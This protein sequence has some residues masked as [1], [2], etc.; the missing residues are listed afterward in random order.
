MQGPDAG[1]TRPHFHG[2]VGFA[3]LTRREQVS[4]LEAFNRMAVAMQVQ[5]KAAPEALHDLGRSFLQRRVI[6]LPC[7]GGTRIAI[8][9]FRHIPVGVQFDPGQEVDDHP[10]ASCGALLDIIGQEPRPLL[11]ARISDRNASGA[12]TVGQAVRGQVSAVGCGEDKREI[13]A[14][15]FDEGLC[16]NAQ[17]YAREQERKQQCAHG[18]TRNRAR[19]TRCRVPARRWHRL[20]CGC[21]RPVARQIP[22]QGHIRS[23]AAGDSW[24]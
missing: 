15:E 12:G 8:G 14:L 16:A 2:C 3:Q 18:A 20:S 10:G 6:D 21:A 19:S 1:K 17:A 22:R 7:L 13:P 23:A 24:Q 11:R 9:G 4:Q 5:Q